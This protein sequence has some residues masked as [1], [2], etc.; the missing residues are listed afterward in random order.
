MTGKYISVI[1]AIGAR[2]K[3]RGVGDC[4]TTLPSGGLGTLSGFEAMLV[5]RFSTPAFVAGCRVWPR[6]RNYYDKYYRSMREFNYHSRVAQLPAAVDEHA[7]VRREFAPCRKKYVRGATKKSLH[8]RKDTS[9][10][11][12]PIAAR[13]ELYWRG[14]ASPVDS[15]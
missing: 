10:N 13:A 1:G 14:P 5:S 3:E 9:S 8:F 11:E 12:I 7:A 2:I 6:R 15:G 4:P